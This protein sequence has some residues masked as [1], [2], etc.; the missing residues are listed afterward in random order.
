MGWL[1]SPKFFCTF[2]EIF[3]DVANTL[4]DTDLL[5]PSYGAIFDIPVTRPGPPHTPESFTQ[6]YCYMDDVV[7]AVQSDPNHQH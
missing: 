3:T 4:V 1:D 2:S 5:V 6:I 7:S